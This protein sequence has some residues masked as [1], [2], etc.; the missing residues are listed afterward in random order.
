MMVRVMIALIMLVAGVS[1]AD[2]IKVLLVDPAHTDTGD[3]VAE[4]LA[5]SRN[6]EVRKVDITQLRPTTQPTDEKVVIWLTPEPSLYTGEALA[7]WSAIAADKS[8]GLMFMGL[9]HDEAGRKSLCEA[10]RARGAFAIG[11][12]LDRH[13]DGANWIWMPGKPKDDSTIFLRKSVE[14]AAVPARAWL[15]IT[16]DNRF[17]ASINGH[18]LGQS[19]DWK[20]PAAYDVTPLV[21]AGKNLLEIEAYNEDGPAGVVAALSASD[22]EGKPL[23]RVVTDDTWVSSAARTGDRREW[24]PAKVVAK[25]GGGEWEDK[26]ETSFVADE[27]AL[28]RAKPP[29]AITAGLSGAI[30]R[31]AVLHGLQAGAGTMPVLMADRIPVAVAAEGAGGRMIVFAGEME[32]TTQR[33][34][35]PSFADAELASFVRAGVWWLA[36][37]NAPE[38][39]AVEIGAA[40]SAKPQAAERTLDASTFF[41]VTMQFS[42]IPYEGVATP[43][44]LPESR[45]AQHRIIDSLIDH[46]C[47]LLQCPL[48]LPDQ[49]AR[50]VERY[51][52]ARGMGITYVFEHGLENVPRDKPPKFSVY[53]DAYKEDLHKRLEARFEVLGRYKNLYNVLPMQDEPFHAGVGSFDLRPEHQKAVRDTYSGPEVTAVPAIDDPKWP[54]F[55]DSNTMDFVIAWL[56]VYKDFK[57]RYPKVSVVLNHDSHNVFGG[58]NGQEGKLFVD[59]VYRW[60]TAFADSLAF[61]IYPYLMKDFRYGPNRE[62]RLPR[63]AQMH[64]AIAQ[65]RNLVRSEEWSIG[66]TGDYRK[67]LGFYVGTYHPEWFALTPAGREQYW[68]SR[69]MAYTAL[70]GGA[71]YL[72]A[73]LNVPIE[74]KH[75]EDFG[76]ALRTIQKA[77][78]ALRAQQGY[79]AP[80]VMMFPRLQCLRTQEEYWNVAQSFEMFQRAFGELDVMHEDQVPGDLKLYNCRMMT[81]FDVKLVKNYVQDSIEKYVRDGGAVLA[82]CVAHDDSFPSEERGALFGVKDAKTG[83]ILWPAKMKAEVETD[84]TDAPKMPPA[85]QPSDAVRGS[86]FGLAFNFPIVSPRPCTVTDGEVL[87]KTANG[88]PA[89]VRKISGSG[90][91]YLLGFCLQDTAFEAWRTGDRKTLGQLYDLLRAITADASVRAGIRSSNPDIEA[92]LRRTKDDVYIIAVAHEPIDPMTTIN[93][94]WWRD[95]PKRVVDIATDEEVPFKLAGDEIE[96]DL[97]LPTGATRLLH[98]LR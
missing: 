42:A 46:G 70:A 69:E 48:P 58:A 98:V 84:P 26:V 97:K 66:G 27:Y 23:L 33:G 59:D 86:A 43:K 31:V 32:K 96:V 44:G 24:K 18:K 82:D 89:L 61:D 80:A 9:P 51:A 95:T 90:R 7:R 15:Q 53:S 16:A 81:L 35:A 19:E 88:A 37:R 85:T 65:M 3:A 64:F 92:S 73:G 41:P 4:S 76:D 91:A 34:T 74:A 20:R 21:H 75:W 87:L 56:Q 45:S 78:P 17:V 47:T 2:Q 94:R 77:G 50:E 39:A 68:M 63:M 71:D 13:L 5:A 1:R 6:F 79:R 54:E 30:G 38:R 14:F 36:D 40:R 28:E 62:L 12:A 55:A 22:A 60:G 52:Q 57:A 10:L 72:I 29:H 93:M 8:I 49:Q 67:P 83:R 25:L 11:P